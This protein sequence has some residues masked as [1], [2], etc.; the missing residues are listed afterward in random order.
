MII[1]FE[2]IENIENL[3]LLL[4]DKNNNKSD[5]SNIVN[6]LFEDIN[7]HNLNKAYINLY[8]QKKIK[9]LPIKNDNVNIYISLLSSSIPQVINALNQLNSNKEKLKDENQ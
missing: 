6:N 4:T 7:Q 9:N 5:F 2:D 1:Y 8:K 3:L